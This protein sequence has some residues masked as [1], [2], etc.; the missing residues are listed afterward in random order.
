MGIQQRRGGQQ[1]SIFDTVD[2]NVI[3]PLPRA[4]GSLQGNHVVEFYEHDTS[5][6]ESVRR[7]TSSTLMNG[8]AAVVVAT[9]MHRAAI[10]LALASD[11]HDLEQLRKDAL[12]HA[13]DADETL[14]L[15]MVED[16]PDPVA[17]IEILGNVLTHAESKA[18]KVRVF[19]EM[20]S[21]LWS[22][23]NP[24]GA[25]KVEGLWNR[26]AMAHR[27]DLL[28]GYPVAQFG[29][30]EISELQAVCRQHSHILAPAVGG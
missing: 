1:M 6:V 12:F 19:G 24:D 30:D 13:L 9:S 8:G 4:R 28:C 22:D 23:G 2:S 10:E 27:F 25:L 11:G 21:V 18:E 15:F 5:L 7:F 17:F 16:E 29:S 14:D 26:L 20:V 3:A